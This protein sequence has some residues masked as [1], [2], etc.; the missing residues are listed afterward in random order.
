M[1]PAAAPLLNVTGR[2]FHLYLAVEVGAVL[3]PGE[4]LALTAMVFP[5]V[6]AHV[7]MEMTTPSGGLERVEGDANEIGIFAMPF[8]V[9]TLQEPGVYSVKAETVYKGERGGVLGTPDDRFL[10]FVVEK[11]RRN[12]LNIDLPHFKEFDPSGILNIPIKV[13]PSVKNPKLTWSIICP[14]IVMDMGSVELQEYEYI[15]RFIP[16]Q[17]AIQFPNFQVV[18]PYKRKM[19]LGKS[20]FFTFFLEGTDESGNKLHDVA[21]LMTRHAKV[22]KFPTKLEENPESKPILESL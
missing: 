11:D 6:P 21:F 19:G 3:H 12:V 9:I 7:T 10:H 13:D 8:S 1:A 17:F 15:Y 20:V 14:G 5:P 4:P 22:I 16:S 18:D 2:D